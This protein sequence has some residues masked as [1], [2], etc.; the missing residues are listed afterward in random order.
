MADST[1]ERG[2]PIPPRQHEP[3][4]HRYP[5]LWALRVGDSFVATK[6]PLGLH[7]GIAMFGIKHSQK[8]EVRKMEGGD[9]RVWRTQ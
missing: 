7:V 5:E 2:V 1:I 4:E 8:H 3:I 9:Y 6:A